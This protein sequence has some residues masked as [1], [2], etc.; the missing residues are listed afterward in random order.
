MLEENKAIQAQLKEHPE[1]GP[2]YEVVVAADSTHLAN[3]GMA[4]LWPIYTYFGN[5]SK[6][7]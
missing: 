6:Y 2:E 3:F 1:P 4:A 7:V 5:L